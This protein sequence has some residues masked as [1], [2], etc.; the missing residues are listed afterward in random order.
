MQIYERVFDILRKKEMSQKELAQKTGISQSTISDW[1]NKGINPSSD[2]IM[3]ICDALEVS[4]Y[5]ILSGT[6]EK[7]VD[8]DYVIIDKKSE[9]FMLIETYRNASESNKNRLFGYAQ[10]IKDLN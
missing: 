1:K 3:I 6:D 4:P 2:K 7:Y 8:V 9:E 5:D 10:A